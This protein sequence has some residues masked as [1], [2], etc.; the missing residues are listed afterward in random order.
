L[1]LAQELTARGNVARLFTR[2]MD[3]S[4]LMRI[5]SKSLIPEFFLGLIFLP[6]LHAQSAPS[7]PAATSASA[8]KA[9]PADQVPDDVMKKLSV[10]VHAGKYP[11]AQQLTAGLLMAYPDDQR[12]IKI[13][14]LLDKSPAPAGSPSATPSPN[15]PTNN[16]PSSQPVANTVAGRFTGMELVDYD[17]MIALAEQAQQTTDLLEQKQLLQ[18]F[19]DQS[20]LFLQQHPAEI[21]LWQLRA[22]SAI[23]LNDP[24]AGSK[25]GQKLLALGG[26]DGADVNLRRLLAQLKNKGWLDQQRME[27]TEKYAWVLG[28]W[29]VSWSSSSVERAFSG[30]G[31]RTTN[32]GKE[33]NEVLSMVGS[34]VE[35]FNMNNDV[36]STDPNMRGT[37]L[38]SG[39]IRW[40]RYYPPGEQPS[41]WQPPISY[42]LSAD[43]RTMTMVVPKQS[44]P[45]QRDGAKYALQHP[46]TLVFEKISDSQSQ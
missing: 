20:F 29:S 7:A 19:M 9:I 30:G 21:L 23:G 40:E 8:A 32:Q 22:A 14:A 26:A 17:A 3:R 44:P 18:Q 15:P 11:E 10:L 24:I 5:I 39:E 46:V 33:A 25:A 28:T 4:K 1:V 37:L 31:H 38:D 6:S 13:K 2:R 35:G 45:G 42:V 43:K 12:L 16:V 36:K 41:G 34:V 27:E